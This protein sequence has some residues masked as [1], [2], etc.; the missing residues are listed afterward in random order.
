MKA[1]IIGRDL[2]VDHTVDLLHKIPQAKLEKLSAR[3]NE[4][5]LQCIRTHCRQVPNGHNLIHGAFGSGNTV[6]V[7]IFC[8][9][10]ALRVKTK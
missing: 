5:Q 7:A 2:S 10:Q 4:S 9:L 3:L 1:H 8:E 6:I